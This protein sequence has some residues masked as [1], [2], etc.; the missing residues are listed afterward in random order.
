MK[1]CRGNKNTNCVVGDFEQPYENFYVNPR[2]KDG[3]TNVCRSCEKHRNKKAYEE[4]RGEILERT[5]AYG[6]ANRD[7]T[8]KAS[9]TYYYKNRKANIQR[10]LDWCKKNPEKAAA[11]AAK[12]RAA[13]KKAT[14]PWLTE[15][16]QEEI[17]QIYIHAKDC[18]LV[19][20][21][22]YHVDHIVPLA[23]VDICGLHVPWNLQ[24][25]PAD[26]NISKSN[27][28]VEEAF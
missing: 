19:S 23:G 18:Q 16:M 5:K 22:R 7:I 15:Q 10:K 17:L 4:N 14:P 11:A 24:V 21:E 25:L 6:K 27:S 3:Y 2:M 28:N 9:K 20:G 13:R 12:Y 8:R 1:T 26:I